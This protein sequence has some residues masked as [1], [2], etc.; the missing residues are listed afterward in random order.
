MP[1]GFAPFGIM[2][3]CHN[4]HLA[5]II[6]KIAYFERR[7]ESNITPNGIMPNGVRPWR[8]CETQFHTWRG[9]T[10]PKDK[11]GPAAA[12]VGNQQRKQIRGG[13]LALNS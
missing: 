4:G 6:R 5:Y 10:E 11:C 2:I 9:Y 8:E 13:T 12:V 1:L 7:N 3:V